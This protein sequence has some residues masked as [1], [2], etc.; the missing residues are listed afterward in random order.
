MDYEK[1]CDQILEI[2]KAIRYVCVYDY[3]EL[4]DKTRKGLQSYLTR[5]ETETSL[6]QAVYRWSTRKKTADKIGKPIFALA[7][8]EKIYRITIPIGGAGLVLVSTELNINT[9]EIIEKI[10]EKILRFEI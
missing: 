9:N 8:Y 5:Q 1:I 4:H 10:L 7:K 6:S 3:G 2:D